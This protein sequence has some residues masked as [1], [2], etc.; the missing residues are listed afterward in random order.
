MLRSAY[1]PVKS[2]NNFLVL[3]KSYLYA[4]G[5]L[6]QLTPATLNSTSFTRNFIFHLF[7]EIR[8]EMNGI[9]QLGQQ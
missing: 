9:N 7:N 2:M 4:E 6:S 3:S 1:L 8:L 5:T